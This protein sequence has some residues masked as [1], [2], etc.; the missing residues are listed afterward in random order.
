MSKRFNL[1]EK[2]IFEA[3]DDP[4]DIGSSEDFQDTPTET[5]DDPPDLSIDANGPTD[6]QNNEPPPDLGNEDSL[7]DFNSE[8][9]IDNVEDEEDPQNMELDEKISAIMNKTL[10]QRFLNLLN[11]IGSHLSM[12]KNNSD[13]LSILASEVL[14]VVDS[15]KKLDENIRLYLDNYFINENYSSNLLFYNKCINLLKLLNDFFDKKVNKGI[16]QIQ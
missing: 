14:D 15:L 7:D 9:N 8:D 5:F 1:F 11:K 3:P 6:E 12:I 10:Y 4:P 13:I 2:V 16:K